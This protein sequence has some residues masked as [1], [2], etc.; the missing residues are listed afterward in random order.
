MARPVGQAG[1]IPVILKVAKLE[2]SL[3]LG[4]AV[5]DIEVGDILFDKETSEVVL[6]YAADCVPFNLNGLGTGSEVKCIVSRDKD[7]ASPDFDDEDT[8]IQWH[9]AKS[10]VTS[11]MS[12]AM[13]NQVKTFGA[14]LVTSRPQ[15]RVCASVSTAVWSNGFLNVYLYYTTRKMDV[16]TRRILVGVE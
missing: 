11:G 7:Q 13:P 5:P 4:D 9:F 1:A 6:I 10:F 12:I 16:E 15:L 3:D 14:P 2:I 8:M